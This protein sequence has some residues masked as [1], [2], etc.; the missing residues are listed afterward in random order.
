MSDRRRIDYAAFLAVRVVQ[1]A[2]PPLLS[3]AIVRAFTPE[4]YGLFQSVFTLVGIL[5]F[6]PG[7]GIDRL[8]FERDA[9]GT[10][11]PAVRRNAV[12][13][14]VVSSVAFWLAGIALCAAFLNN[15]QA[16]IFAGSLPIFMTVGVNRLGSAVERARDRFRYA[17]TAEAIALATLC[18]GMIAVTVTTG[19]RNV[20]AT[21]AVPAIPYLVVSV[22]FHA[23][24][25]WIPRGPRDTEQLSQAVAAMRRTWSYGLADF[26]YTIYHQS[27]VIVLAALLPPRNVGLYAV[28]V[29]FFGATAAIPIVVLN[30]LLYPKLFRLHVHDHKRYLRTL[31]V[32]AWTLS[33]LGLA[34]YTV[35]QLFGQH[36][37]KTMFGT[38]YGPAAPMIIILTA[39][40]PV[41]FLASVYQAALTTS[42]RIG[43][44]TRV[45]AV[46]AATNLGLNVALVPRF[47]AV[48]AAWTTLICESALL[49]AF[50]VPAL[51]EVLGRTSDRQAGR[52]AAPLIAVGAA[53]ATAFVPAAAAGLTGGALAAVCLVGALIAARPLRGPAV[54]ARSAPEH[55]VVAEPDLA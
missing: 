47:G 54:T 39:A 40:I 33:G 27:D 24:S 23:R 52:A 21:I 12:K 16:A 37:L 45:Q 49:I 14:V 25:L 38:A 50:A 32:A 11:T 36:I 19:G 34:G 18:F 10:L 9:A 17:A 29:K 22:A 30:D 41:R 26:L 28:A 51:R 2:L 55:R 48:T 1:R 35:V 3:L 4:G 46:V 31:S 5:S 13:F 43:R 6:G 8:F 15:G 7:F 44:Q 20:A 42:G 53:V